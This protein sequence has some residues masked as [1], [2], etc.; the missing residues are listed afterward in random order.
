M[1][2]VFYVLLSVILTGVLLSS[3]FAK[4]PSNTKITFWDENAGP[5]RTPYYE[6]L[7][8]RFEQK[9]PGIQVEY[10]GLPWSNAK[11]KYDVAIAANAEPD[12]GGMPLIYVSSF[13]MKKALIDLDGY[14]N[15]WDQKNKISKVILNANRSISDNHRLY[16]LPNTTTMSVLWYREDVY[17]SLGLTVPK[18]WDQFYEN[19]RKTTDKNKNTYGFSLRGGPG[20]VQQLEDLMYAYS[21]I[22][23]YFTKN[24]KCT[25]NAPKNVEALKR[26]VAMFK[27]YTQESD[28]TNG[29]K[30]MVAAFD[31][32]RAMM[33]QHNLGSYGEHLKVFS[34]DQF[35]ACPF[36]VSITGKRVIKGGQVDGY[37]IFRESKH[38]EAAWRFISY[39]SSSDA[40]SYWNYN[41]GQLPTNSDVYN[42][43][44]VKK[45]PHVKMAGQILND[46]NSMV[47]LQPFHLP[48]YSAILSQ[49]VEP[50]FQ[51]VL[52][53]KKTPENFLNEWASAMEKANANYNKAN[54]K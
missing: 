52:L 16:M 12:C 1:K 48:D 18:T 42:E 40:Q 38:P 30:E 26:F 49:F 5:N 54:K 43:D 15:K 24:G 31:S 10:V 22:T 44:W 47:M 17:K 45:F 28:I 32:G 4:E 46:K 50:S 39:L 2:K 33:I 6:E 20:S 7:I 3:V 27:V 36:P 14:F 13:I 11:Q 51:E 37:G 21:G 29:Y 25:V 23:S 9:N 8:K 34:Q 19:I 35:A 53:G 41:I